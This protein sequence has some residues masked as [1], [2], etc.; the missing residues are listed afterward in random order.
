MKILILGT[1]L[2]L[3]A[4]AQTTIN[5]SRT[6]LGS[7][8]ASGAA[9]TKPAKAGTATPGTCTVGEQF[10]E[11]DA[12]AGSNIWLCTATNVWTQIAGTGGVTGPTGPTGTSGATGAQGP[13][14]PAGATGATGTGTTG[15][16]G[17]TGSAGSNGSTGATGPTG[18]AGATGATGSGTLLTPASN[19]FSTSA[20]SV[21]VTHNWG[22]GTGD[23]INYS[24]VCGIGDESSAQPFLV[25]S[26][27]STSNT[28]TFNFSSAPGAGYCA[29]SSTSASGVGATGPTGP[30]GA[31]GS[32]GATGATGATGTGVTGTEV[33]AAATSGGDN[34]LL[35]AVGD[36]RAVEG[37]TVQI[38]DSNEVVA[39]GFRTAA[40]AVA[41]LVELTQGTA[42]TPSANSVCRY[43]PASI[44]TAYGVVEPSAV[45][46]SGVVKVSV[47]GAVA[48]L[49]HAALVAADIPASLTSTTSVN[50][51]TIPSSSTLAVE[52]AAGT[53]A[54]GTSAISSGACAT[55]VTTSATG[56]TTTDVIKAGFNG[57]PTGVT[58]YTPSASGMLTIIPYPSAN[59]VNFKVCNNTGGS[60]TPGAIT[61]NWR[62]DR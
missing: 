42:C 40:S 4:S 53:S 2:A 5:G 10:F 16:T 43:A 46:A 15:A 48:T 31:T 26:I 21:V 62:V 33:T 50:S 30:A 36:S 9:S 25:N 44:G 35:R 8:D 29:V 47:S 20:T 3:G 18:A 11:T 19:T 49:S 13:T 41:G 60:I 56:V 37:T 55:V 7:W 54:L 39:A 12:T 17:P 6:I 45:G 32:A 28:V 24:W 52:I 57:D 59:N 14:G 38:N 23:E 58:G 27:V 51:T 34:R 1:L 61:L 22:L